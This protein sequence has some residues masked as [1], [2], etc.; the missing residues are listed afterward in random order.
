MHIRISPAII[1]LQGG[2]GVTSQM[3]LHISVPML[4]LGVLRFAT[5]T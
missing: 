1:D 5:K 2:S 4:A 3:N